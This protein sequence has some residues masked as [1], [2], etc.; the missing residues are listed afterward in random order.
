MFAPTELVFPKEAAKE[1]KKRPVWLSKVYTYLLL[2]MNRLSNLQGGS[3]SS[4]FSPSL[5]VGNSLSLAAALESSRLMASVG[6]VNRDNCGMGSDALVSKS[7]GGLLSDRNGSGVNDFVSAAL[8]LSHAATRGYPLTGLSSSSSGLGL[9]SDPQLLLAVAE[10]QAAENRRLEFVRA[11]LVAAETAAM[12]QRAVAEEAYQ[13]G[14]DEALLS[15]VRNGAV[16]QMPGSVNVGHN[17]STPDALS[18]PA[19]EPRQPSRPK[20]PEDLLEALG[21]SLKKKNSEYIDASALKDPDPS[22][23]E[24]RRTRGGVTEP[25]PEK[26]HRMLRE[27]EETGNADIISFFSHGRA[28]GVHKPEKFVNEVLPKWFKQTRLSSFQRQLNLY[29]FT[30]ISSGPDA[31]GYYHE[32]FLKGR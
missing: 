18:H 30:R 14:H 5:P 7:R 22:L 13:R 23:F 6:G 29:G 16:A 9:A 24:R 17:H 25:F 26:L 4:K 32:L 15:L 10:Q 21:S 2:T 12:R 1:V 19:T 20:K 3:S 11:T 31:G 27:L 8:R 28:F